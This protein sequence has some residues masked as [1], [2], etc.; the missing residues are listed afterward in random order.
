MASSPLI[1]DPSVPAVPDVV[2]REEILFVKLILRAVGR[3]A[4]DRPPEPRQA[5]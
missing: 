4:R 1:A 2:F 3:R 5:A